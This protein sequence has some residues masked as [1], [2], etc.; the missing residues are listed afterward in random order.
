MSIFDTAADRLVQNFPV[1]R[2]FRKT[3]IAQAVGDMTGA[4]GEL[5]LKPDGGKFVVG[6]NK[7]AVIVVAGALAV[8]G[9]IAYFAMAHTKGVMPVTTMSKKDTPATVN[10][11]DLPK[12]PVYTASAGA[13]PAVGPDGK[14]IAGTEGTTPAGTT[15][16][17]GAGN[18]PQNG[19]PQQNAQPSPQQ[20]A[21]TAALSGQSGGMS[22]QSGGTTKPTG[23]TSPAGSFAPVAAATPTAVS[24]PNSQSGLGVYDTHLLRK[25]ASPFEVMQGNVI[26]ATLTTGIESDLPGQITAIVSRNI[27]DSNSGNSLLIPAGASLVGSYATKVLPGQQSVAVAWNRV[28]FPNG[29]YINLGTMEGSDGNGMSGLSGDV[30]NHTWL[31]FKN[32]LL[33]SLVTTGMALGQPQTNSMYPTTNQMFTQ[34]FSQ[35]FG[36]A[37][38]QVLMQY[39]TIAPTIHVQAGDQIMVIVSKDL[40]FPSAYNPAMQAAV[41]QDAHDAA[42]AAMI[43][44]Y[45]RST[46]K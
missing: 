16:Q 34:Q 10:N 28:V 20:Q 24:T 22:W 9:F 41:Q 40:V 15:G 5:E 42:P 1:S 39:A 18:M 44:P 23:N 12:Q 36:Q 13:T 14:P 4:P 25:E 21:T 31:M 8:V 26:P 37:V 43:N 6:M 19:Q 45:P 38:S 30:D 33:L 46:N 35:T 29:T 11:M 2:R 3:P 32:A 7:N 27:Y 17:T